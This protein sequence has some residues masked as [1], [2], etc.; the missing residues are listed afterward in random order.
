MIPYEV[1]LNAAAVALG[2]LGVVGW[3]VWREYK[4]PG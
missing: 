4:R 1:A 2:W 3:I